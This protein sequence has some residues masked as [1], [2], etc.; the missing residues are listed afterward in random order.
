MLL[1]CSR[2]SRV[3]P[4]DALFCY[5]DG[6]ALG[7]P[8]RRHGVS[9]PARQRFPV[10]FIFP[11]GKACHSFDE[12]ALAI[13][14]NWSAARG[15]LEHGVFASF[16]AGLGRAD[17]ST[18][19]HEAAR[20]PN[21][22]RG[23]DQLLT[24]LPT[25][26]IQPPRLVV[27]PGQLNLGT[28]RPGQD[29]PFE[30]RLA[31]H[32]MGLLHGT[33]QCEECPWL[34]LGDPA[35]GT[36]KKLFQF[37][38]ETT[39]RVNVCG[40]SLRAGSRPQQGRIV[41]DSIG[42]SFTVVVSVDV[43]IQVFSD[44]VLT[45]AMTPRQIAEKAR[46]NP[47]EAADLF[48]RG[49]VAKWYESNGWTYPVQEP[50][51]SGLAAVQQFFE[52]LGLTTP[53]KVGISA[54]DIRLEGRGGDILRSSLQVV[55][56]ER[57]PVFA[58]AVSDQSWLKVNE[59]ALN[60]RIATVHLR[61]PDV[62]D[63]PGET[64]HAR[65]SI[66]SNGRQ[67]FVVPVSLSVSG[68]RGVG[69]LPPLPSQLPP[70]PPGPLTSL[71]LTPRPP[72]PKRGEGEKDEAIDQ[73]EEVIL[74]T[75]HLPDEVR[76]VVAAADARNLPPLPPPGR[77][78]RRRERR[79]RDD[80][81]FE[82]ESSGGGRR[83]LVAL[84]PVAFLLIGLLIALVHDLFALVGTAWGNAPDPYG[85]MPQVL[86]VQFHDEEIGVHL[87]A[88]GG[89]KPAPGQVGGDTV[90]ATWEPSMRFG[91]S[92]FQP[93]SFG[94]RKKLTYDE[95]GLTNNTCVRLD[96]H[97]WLFG[98]R[99]FHRLDGWPTGSW[100]GRWYNRNARLDRPLRD[101]HKSIWFYED[102]QVYITQT[103]G[104]VPGEQSGKLD[105]CLIHYRI[106][107]KHKFAH[108]VGLR[109][110][111]DTFIGGNDGVPFLI[112]GWKQLCSTSMD[113]Q[114]AADVPDFLQARETE[115]L[116]NPGT[117]AH[118]QLKIPG[119]EPPARVTIGAW[120]NVALGRG[121]K[122]EKTLWEVPVLP[123][124][125]IPPGDSAV[126]IYWAERSLLPGESREVAFAYGLGS[127]A[128]SEGGGRLALTAGGAFIPLGEFTL[129][130][131][132]NNPVSRQ[133]LSLELP[134]GFSLITGQEKEPVPNL[135]FDGSSSRTSPVTWKIRA[136]SREGKYTI[137]VRSSTGVSQTQQVT[138]RARGIFGN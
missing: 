120:P 130:A 68:R 95:K 10:P 88:T 60:G 23:L 17:L 96:G 37:L 77:P 128:G 43:P 89:V 135:P 13:L 20:F 81:N 93:D 53:P 32:G 108:T 127:V 22:D 71:P 62:P 76:E 2:C 136:S 113:F 1:T 72:L 75:E 70:L 118:I 131:Y 38:N 110:L 21:R 48:A 39:L 117:I 65:L 126:V 121:A 54:A 84:L 26:V 119:M 16:L 61:V 133:T 29:S 24:A 8:A 15:L 59:V 41:I 94:R 64:L 31:N 103:V 100:P 102:E 5:Y 97:E 124:K 129:T 134:E 86:A 98:E 55:T 99:P 63:R 74:V 123:I 42:G 44:G 85:D 45:G 90:P 69:P 52:A 3:N 122:Q 28:K 40:K 107:N 114:V 27:E 34:S 105:T 125:S 79:R 30:L 138:I 19:A 14:D 6:A 67:R 9:D 57:R 36:R 92:M 49:T 87:T 4:S 18:A 112:P 51:A 132:V 115:D 91:L 58:H 56:Q 116:T 47:R 78:R 35:D 11:S 111:L 7:D 25:S 50:S 83:T 80:E 12:L 106:D 66:T 82:G 46:K 101:G 104:L 137:R 73:L 109:F 33:I